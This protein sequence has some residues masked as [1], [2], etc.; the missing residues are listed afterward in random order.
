MPIPR[1]S[2]GECEPEVTSP[3]SA[4]AIPWR[5]IAC[6]VI[7]NATSFRSGPRS[8]ALG[9]SWAVDAFYGFMHLSERASENPD[10]MA[11]RYGGHAHLFGAGL[12][13]QR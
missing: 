8:H 7:R 11:A 13:Y 4:I 6:S 12:R 10:S 1:S 9:P 2:I 3:P 5:G